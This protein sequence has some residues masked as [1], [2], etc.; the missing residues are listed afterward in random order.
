[1]KR[2]RE[3]LAKGDTDGLRKTITYNNVSKPDVI[4]ALPEQFR[5]NLQPVYVQLADTH[6]LVYL[7][8]PHSPRFFYAVDF[9]D[10][11]I[12]KVLS[13]VF[14]DYEAEGMTKK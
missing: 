8:V 6:C 13:A 3:I 5:V 11:E 10:D 7:Q 9:S 2:F 14:L 12:P 1:M 4:A